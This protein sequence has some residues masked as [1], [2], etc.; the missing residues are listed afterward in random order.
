MAETSNTPRQILERIRDE[1]HPAS[2][3]GR[4]VSLSAGDR[5]FEFGRAL[6]LLLRETTLR[7]LPVQRSILPK[8]TGRPR[9]PNLNLVYSSC[10]LQATAMLHVFFW[11]SR[12]AKLELTF[13]VADWQSGIRAKSVGGVSEPGAPPDP[14][15]AGLKR[16]R[17]ARSHNKSMNQ[18]APRN[19]C[20]GRFFGISARNFR[21]KKMKGM[22]R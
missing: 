15:S 22:N 2:R 6:F 21:R 14:L 11:R 13:V 8:G 4:A 18:L 1:T 10:I 5:R 20:S 9:L 16:E 7:K 17:K 19:S 12:F 3:R